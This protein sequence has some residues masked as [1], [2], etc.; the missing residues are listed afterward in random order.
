MAPRLAGQ[1]DGQI[2][3][4]FALLLTKQHSRAVVV[5]LPLR[6]AGRRT[7]GLALSVAGEV[8]YILLAV[9]VLYYYLT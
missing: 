6:W 5:R 9:L 2:T 3:A 1:A 8:V 4:G 7:A